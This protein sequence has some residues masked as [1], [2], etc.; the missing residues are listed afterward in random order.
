MLLVTAAEGGWP[1]NDGLND[2]GIQNGV[3]LHE[4]NWK[5]SG[6]G[7]SFE[8]CLDLFILHK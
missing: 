4:S 6:L 8:S 2:M 5:F 7:E 1:E 3:R